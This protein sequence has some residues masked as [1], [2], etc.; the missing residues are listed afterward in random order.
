MKLDLTA[1]QGALDAAAE[2][3]AFYTENSD[4]E[5]PVA[6][7]ARSASVKGFEMVYEVSIKM[8]RRYLADVSAIPDEIGEM[9]FWDQMR[10]AQS[11][12][13][14]RDPAAFRRY[15]ELRNIS[16]HTYD[17]VKALNIVNALPD[18]LDEAGYL[19]DRLRRYNDS[20]A[21]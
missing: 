5:G 15:R 1:L 12:G 6:R 2:S 18:V 17:A 8:I 13:L 21:D 16:S 19:M 11:R 7:V 20:H 14:I 10:E 3:L 9:P 4:K